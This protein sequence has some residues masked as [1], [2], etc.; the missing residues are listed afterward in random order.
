VETLFERAAEA[1]VRAR[2]G[3]GFG[4]MP[5]AEPET[6]PTALAA[7]ALDDEGARAWLAGAQRDD[8]SF[9]VWAGPFDND[10]ATALAALALPAGSA[11]ERA[12]DHVVTSPA[13][14][15][16]PDPLAPHDPNLAGWGWA[17][18]TAGWVEPTARTLLALRLLRPKTAGAI[19]QAAAFLAD[20]E[21]VDGGWNFGNRIVYDEPLPP[22]GQP[23]AVALVGLHGMTVNGADG[24]LVTRGVGSLRRLW[25]VETGPLTLGTT[26]AAFRLLDLPDAGEVATELERTL[27]ASAPDVIA[28]AWVALASGPGLSRLAVAP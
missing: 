11:R 18:G 12:L 20:R 24:D 14:R 10:S 8:G 28:L 21:C 5:G 19:E 2:S 23:T 25:P 16:P 27:D 13:R 26:L 7:L 17:G 4:P 15:V 3:D 6:E 9:G 1:L 22:F